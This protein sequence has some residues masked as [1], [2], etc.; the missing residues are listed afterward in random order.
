MKAKRS[1]ARD[2]Y[3]EESAAAEPS[4]QNAGDENSASVQR[5]EESVIIYE[6]DCSVSVK[7]DCSKEGGPNFSE[8]KTSSTKRYFV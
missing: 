8:K 2:I 5:D 3:S 7:S 1:E 4:G 6:A